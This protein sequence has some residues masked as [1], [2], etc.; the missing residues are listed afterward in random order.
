ME[1][2][3]FVR[4]TGE[5]KFNYDLE[6]ETITDA[7][8]KPVKAFIEALYKI[9]SSNAV[10]LEDDLILCDNFREEIEKVIAQYPN[11]II[12]FFTKP[13]LY[14]TTHYTDRFDYNQCTYYPKGI[15]KVLADGI[16]EIYNP[17]AHK[18]W[19]SLTNR[20]LQNMRINHVV[21]RP[22]LVQHKDN[23]SILQNGVNLKRNTMWFKGY[24][25]EIGCKSIEQAYRQPYYTKL[26]ACLARDRE[27]W[28]KEAK[29]ILEE[30]RNIK[31]ES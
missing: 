7:I 10:L 14:F 9:S 1:I 28:D 2:K 15:A 19:A 4:T 27:I 3:Y 22:A 6:Y 8:N 26:S 16:S 24:L 11:D 20:V 12:N 18:S 30:R 25:D 31:N 21:H 17:N 29:Q 23:V 5:R 13:E